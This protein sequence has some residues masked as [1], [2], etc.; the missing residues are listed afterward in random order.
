MPT[1]ALKAVDAT[2]SALDLG[3]RHRELTADPCDRQHACQSALYFQPRQRLPCSDDIRPTSEAGERFLS[4]G[5]IGTH[6]LMIPEAVGPWTIVSLGARA[7]L[8]HEYDYLT[9]SP[10][11]S[12]RT[13]IR[14][15]RLLPSS[16]KAWA[17]ESIIGCS[18]NYCPCL[19][20]CTVCWRLDQAPICRCKRIVCERS[21]NCRSQSL[22]PPEL[23]DDQGQRINIGKG[24]P[25]T[26]FQYEKLWPKRELARGKTW[27]QDKLAKDRQ[28][29]IVRPLDRSSARNLTR[30]ICRSRH[31]TRSSPGRPVTTASETSETLLC[32]YLA[33]T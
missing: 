23:T 10:G 31:P 3:H 30:R 16:R 7:G 27:P 9:A 17:N 1:S 5:S 18:S 4:G 26:T 20:R 24:G 6:I 12:M 29:F 11:G 28:C 8:A 22:K 13:G 32:V 14:D 21:A 2:R 25:P 19:T 15:V 33:C